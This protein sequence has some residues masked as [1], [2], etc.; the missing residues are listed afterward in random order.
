MW[1]DK[2]E[3]SS[4][5][6]QQCL[7]GKDSKEIRDLLD[8]FDLYMYCKIKK[9]RKDLMEKLSKQ[10]FQLFLK[11]ID[12]RMRLEFYDFMKKE[13]YKIN[14]IEIILNKEKEK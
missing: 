4:W 8:G 3:Q 9:P 5:A 1:I 11:I 6:R 7:N 12:S 14:N 2:K 13:G 10:S